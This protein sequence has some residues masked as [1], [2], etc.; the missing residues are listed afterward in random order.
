MSDHQNPRLDE[1]TTKPPSGRRVAQD[2][3]S[4]LG[5]SGILVVLI[6]LLLPAFQ[7]TRCGGG[8]PRSEHEEMQQRL[9]L[10]EQAESQQPQAEATRPFNLNSS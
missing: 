1:R 3:L 10:I 6:A 8:A 7:A 4:C 9:R 5:C 2:A